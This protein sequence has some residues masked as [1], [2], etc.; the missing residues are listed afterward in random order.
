MELRFGSTR[1]W[2]LGLLVALAGLAWLVAE[3]ARA[4]LP[5]S[6]GQ[7]Y[8]FGD[9]SGQLG[10]TTNNGTDNQNPTPTLVTLPGGSR[11]AAIAL[12]QN[13]D[14]SVVAVVDLAVTPAL[15]GMRVSPHTTSTGGR[16]VKGHCV[17]PT[18]RNSAHR[19]C[20]KPVKHRITFDLIGAGD[21]TLSLQ[22]IAAGRVVG[23]R[24]VAP[25]RRNHIH[26]HCTR[27]T[28]VP[29]TVTVSGHGGVNSLTIIGRFAG[30]ALTP[31]S[32]QLT[33]TAGAGGAPQTT[34]FTITG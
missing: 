27:I 7:L 25:T 10:S 23:H 28:P 24:C 29:G 9:Y 14:D 6:G 31:G 20:T 15:S 1:L 12:G 8:A 3:P 33:A 13:A 19:Q 16:L 34:R 26:R 22:R 18:P 30:H 17:A 5:I 11:I 4:N 32:Y 2:I 21:V